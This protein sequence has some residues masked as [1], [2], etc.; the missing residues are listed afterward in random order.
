MQ[1][2]IFLLLLN[3]KRN[4]SK[5]KLNKMQVAQTILNQLGGN[6]FI[7]MTGSKNF[8]ASENYLRMN[9]TKN[10]AKAKWLKITLNGKDLYDMHFF[11][12]DK[13]CNITT[14]VKFEDVYFD[15][16]QSLFIKATGLYT[17]L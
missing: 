5:L 6:K 13:E 8:V 2:Q 4:N 1:F 17:S 11:T 16:L 10:K 15:Q 12:A 3:S 14:K 7:V 9:L